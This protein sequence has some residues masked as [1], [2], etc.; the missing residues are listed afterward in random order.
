MGITESL[1]TCIVFTLAC[2]HHNNDAILPSSCAN[3]TFD[4]TTNFFRKMIY[5]GIEKNI[6]AGISFSLQT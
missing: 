1:L 5:C 2:T 6:L 4:E 3:F